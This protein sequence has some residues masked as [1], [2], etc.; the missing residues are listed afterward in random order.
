[1]I[2]SDLRT[3]L[4]QQRRVSL[5]DLVTHFNIDADALRGMLSKWIAKAMSVLCHWNR[6]VGQVAVNVTPP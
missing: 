6:P 4:Q 1:M 2:L 3:Y 5:A